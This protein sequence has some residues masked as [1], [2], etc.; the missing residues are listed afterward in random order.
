MAVYALTGRQLFGDM[1]D[2]VLE[3]GAGVGCG[4]TMIYPIEQS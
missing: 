1:H 4:D 3:H 2:M